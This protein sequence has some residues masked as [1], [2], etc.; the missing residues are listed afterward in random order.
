MATLQDVAGPSLTHVQQIKTDPRQ[1][2]NKAGGFVFKVNDFDRLKRFLVLGSESGTY[3]ASGEELGLENVKCVT[4]LLRN[5]K[6]EQVIDII[7]EFSIEGRCPKQTTLVYCLALCARF[8]EGKH[9]E[10]YMKIHQGAYGILPDVCRIPTDLFQFVQFC[11]DISKGINAK[12]GWGRAHR[13]AIGNWYLSK[14]GRKLAYL[15]TKYKQRNGW[16]HKDLLRLSHPKTQ[17]D[18]NSHAVVFK[19]IIKGFQETKMYL[20]N[21][22]ICPS[23]EDVRQTYDILKAVNDASSIGKA[24]DITENEKEEKILKLIEDFDLVREQIPTPFLKSLK[25]NL[26]K[27]LG[28]FFPSIS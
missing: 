26:P 13:R 5:G 12:T 21:P 23:V 4:E 9:G 6:G 10:G 7:K 18:M 17:N 2:K 14:T 16:S 1:V 25:V 28:N 3:Y 19:Y 11:E 24:T 27:V 20:E 8:H 15:V 22:Q